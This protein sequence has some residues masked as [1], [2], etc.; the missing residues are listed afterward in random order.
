MG[1]AYDIGPQRISW[2]VQMLTD[3][4]GDDGF[5][6]TLSASVNRPNLL[7]DTTTWHGTVTGKD[8]VDG[9]HLISIDMYA[10]N[11][12][13]EKNSKA[14]ATVLLPSKVDGPV[15]TPIPRNLTAD[16]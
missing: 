8:V 13:G 15:V 7:G 6:H 3:W 5:L 14:T 12:R 16:K 11:Q 9:Y 2:G 1:G 10:D 4:M